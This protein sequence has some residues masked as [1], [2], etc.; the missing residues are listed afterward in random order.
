VPL[1]VDVSTRLWLLGHGVTHSPSPAMQNAA[2][3][4][5][6]LDWEYAIRDVAPEALPG[7]LAELRDGAAAGC[8]VTIPHKRAVAAASDAL[9][10]D[11]ELTGAVNTV[12]R[13]GDGLLVGHNTDA[14]GLEAALRHD[15]LWP[16]PG[17]IVVV[18]GA[19][20]AAAAALLAMLRTQPARLHVA[21]RRPEAARALGAALSAGVVDHDAGAVALA[22]RGA[23]HSVLVNAT[24][25]ALPELP[26]ELGSLPATCTVVDLRYRCAAD[27]L[28]PSARA[29][30]LR[31]TDGLEMLL[32]QGMLSFE[33][34]TGR[35]APVD[36]ARRALH[37]AVGRP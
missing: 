33:L 34:W 1:A 7:V 18:L 21:A 32:Q 25:A 10:G 12:V 20:G 22:L 31:A 19:G 11:A 9:D 2:L 27:D 4:S 36:A 14:R 29:R 35:P 26:V 23:P 8:N 15:A 17:A 24:P 16:E 6:G 37:A 30:G 5:A 3:R 13:S 28:V